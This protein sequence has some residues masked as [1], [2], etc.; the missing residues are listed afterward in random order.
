MKRPKN[1]STKM[2]TDFWLKARRRARV[3]LV[4]LSAGLLTACVPRCMRS[5]ETEQADKS[6][7]LSTSRPSSPEAASAENALQ[8]TPQV[9]RTKES[10]IVFLGDSLTAGYELPAA[11]AFPAKVK[12]K[13]AARHPGW[14]VVN[15]GVSGDTTAG[16]VARL[17]WV[18][19]SKPDVLFICLGAND[20]LRGIPLAETEKN[21][22]TL[23]DRATRSA[24]QVVLAG[25]M[26]PANYG[27]DYRDGFAGLFPKLAKEFSVPLMPFLIDKVALVPELTLPD[28]IHPNAR[29]TEVIAENVVKVI[30]PLLAARDSVRTGA[31]S[32]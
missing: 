17:D 26:L 28:G 19:K 23:L 29:G 1:P 14:K 18:L 6:S 10:V 8:G 25:M 31:S 27:A 15:A 11:E 7:P 24:P 2:R 22:R 20:G 16:G 12:E 32:P 5:P 21:L 9:P 30:A 4:C 3:P 13:I